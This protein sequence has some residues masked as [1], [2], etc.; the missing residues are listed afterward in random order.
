MTQPKSKRVRKVAF[1]MSALRIAI[2]RAAVHLRTKTPP[3]ICREDLF[4]AALW[5][6]GFKVVPIPTRRR[7]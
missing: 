3:V 6:E 2:S 5:R 7:K 1:P 4:L